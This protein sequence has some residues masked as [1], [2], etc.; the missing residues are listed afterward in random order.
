[1][2]VLFVETYHVFLPAWVHGISLEM[3]LHWLKTHGRSGPCNT[4]LHYPHVSF[5]LA[6]DPHEPYDGYHGQ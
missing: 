6:H 4:H 5:E 2:L 3:K 1:M